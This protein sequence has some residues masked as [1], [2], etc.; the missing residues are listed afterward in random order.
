M[1][2]TEKDGK[3]GVHFHKSLLGTHSKTKNKE[4]NFLYNEIRKWLQLQHHKYWG[5]YS[6]HCF[7]PFI[8]ETTGDR[9]SDT[10]Q[11][12]HLLWPKRCFKRPIL[13]CILP[14]SYLMSQ[15]GSSLHPELCNRE[16]AGLLVP[17]PLPRSCVISG[18]SLYLSGLQCRHL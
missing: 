15:N 12:S 14:P 5:L 1:Y 11:R 13:L 9:F 3:I 17:I 4:E 10:T 18:I 8:T 2:T 7:H 6:R 16:K